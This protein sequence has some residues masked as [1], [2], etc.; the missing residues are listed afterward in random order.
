MVKRIE[1]LV[2]A[3]LLA[4]LG[5]C[6]AGRVRLTL[7]EAIHLACDSSLQAFANQNLYA[8]GYWEWKSFR[9]KRLPGLTLSLEPARYYRYIAQRYDSENNIDVFRGQELYSAAGTLSA[10]Q[11]VDFLGGTLYM[12]SGL[13]F[14]HNFGRYGGD[15]YNSTPFRIGYRQ[16]LIGFNSFRWER[17]IEPLK[18]E[19]VKREFIYNME[20]LSE[21]VVRCFFALAQ[22]QSEYALAVDNIAGSDTLYAIGERRFRIASISQSD[23]LTLRLD[24]INAENALE[25][26]RISIQRAMMALAVRI[27]LDSDTEIEVSLPAVPAVTEIDM[28]TALEH[29]HANNPTLLSHRQSVLEAERDEN[30]TRIESYF[31]ASVNASVGFNQVGRSLR[32]AYMHPER[33]D[34]VSVSLTI[35]LVDWGVRRGKHH[36]AV[37]TLNLARLAQRQQELTVEQEVRNTIGDFGVHQRLVNSA[38]EA[39]DLADRAY[40]QTRQRF[41]IG[42]TDINSLTLSHGRQQEATRNYI[43]SLENYWL[44]YYKL[45]RL[46]LFDFSRGRSIGADFDRALGVH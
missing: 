38:L 41:M 13:E 11:N 30:R 8:S 31:N 6:A 5:C 40:L 26:A 15:Q 14:M 19:K 35:P 10:T 39:V 16:E 20:L 17:R 46:T 24:K 34:L 36:T 32:G 28:G 27:G 42:K 4:S 23:L 18:Y 29:A 43:S 44:S 9:A 22:A 1:V 7:D 3:L 12:E 2:A 25:N 33:Q 37:N 21:D 45:R